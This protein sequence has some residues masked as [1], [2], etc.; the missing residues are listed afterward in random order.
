MHRERVAM[1][2]KVMERVRD[3]KLPFDMEVWAKSSPCG[4]A[5]CFA[6]HL[7]LS[8]EFRGI[9]MEVDEEYNLPTLD[10]KTG[11]KAVAAALDIEPWAAECLCFSTFYHTQQVK[12]QDVIDKLHRL[13]EKG[14]AGVV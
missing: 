5:A 2:I 1:A 7:A 14:E 4:T 10:I 9:G 3:Q 12:P 6:G 11:T 13:L 8:Y